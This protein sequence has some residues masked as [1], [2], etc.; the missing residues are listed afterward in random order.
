MGNA[1][2]EKGGADTLG[3]AAEKSRAFSK[4]GDYPTLWF[5]L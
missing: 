4:I 1:Q 5:K 3:S 2:A